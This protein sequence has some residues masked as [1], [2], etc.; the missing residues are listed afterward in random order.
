MILKGQ[1]HGVNIGAILLT[2][3]VGKILGFVSF[4]N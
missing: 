4:H 1:L 3:S 2:K